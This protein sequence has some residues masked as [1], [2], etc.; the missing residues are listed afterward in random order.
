MILV[1]AVAI[2]MVFTEKNK[3]TEV[4]LKVG[5]TFTVRLESNPSTGYRWLFDSSANV[6][7]VGKDKYEKIGNHPEDFVGAP[8][9]QVLVFKVTKP[10]DVTFTLHYG[11]SWDRK[12]SDKTYK[13]LL[14]VK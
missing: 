11:R 9:M 4:D 2:A 13:L 8:V 1:A 3:D 12:A 10:G 7:Q 6:E 14:K 5:D